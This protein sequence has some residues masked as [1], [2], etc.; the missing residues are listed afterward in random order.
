MGR[1]AVL[2]GDLQVG[3]TRNYPF[4]ADLVPRAAALAAAAREQG[5]LVVFVRTQL[6]VNGADVSARNAGVQAIFGMG[7]DY[8]EGSTG[9]ELDP[10]LGCHTSDVI[11][12]KRRASAFA[13]TDLDVVL[14]SSSVDTLVVAGVATSAMVAA[15]VYDA[16]DRDF[17]V[18][19]AS[20]VCADPVEA[21]HDFVVGA[22]FP[23]RGVE[24]VTVI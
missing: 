3:V 12:T 15:T 2:I 1:L 17:R 10:G 13:G 5:N 4:A 6:R 16:A 21:V 19:V 11:V 18:R 7:E 20:D 14:R 9:V 23:A 24:I 22:L 8:R